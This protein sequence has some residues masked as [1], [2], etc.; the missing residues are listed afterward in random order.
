MRYFEARKARI[1]IIPMIDI[2]FFMLVFFIMITLHMIPN[3]GL[4]MRLPSSASAQSVPPPKVTVTL[5][6]DGSVSVD[7]H[8]FS[9]A[10]LTALLAKRP[11]PA[12]TVVTIEGAWDAQLQ[13]LVNVMD[14][15]RAAGVT[16]VSL[17]AQPEKVD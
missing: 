13:K 3:A 5:A 7:G 2:M 11:D 16:Q 1:E 10:D 8:T 14:A 17:A 6:A 12:H 4:R 15:C 9:T